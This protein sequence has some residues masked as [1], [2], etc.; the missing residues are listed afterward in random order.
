ME[1]KKEQKDAIQILHKRYITDEK[2]KASLEKERVNAEVA[3]MIHE[4]RVDAELSQ[5]ELADLI[6]TT[7]SVISRLEDD[8]Y[9]GHS[10]SMLNKISKALNKRLTIVMKTNDPEAGTLRYA[11]QVTL[12]NLRR[13]KGLT[14]EQLA[15]KTGISHDEVLAME[16]NDGYRPQPYTLHILSKFYGIP[17]ERLAALAGAFRE[18]PEDIKES[19]TRYAAQSESFAKLTKQE[20]RALDD[21]VKA[22]KK[23]K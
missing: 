23:D 3:R 4:L 11:F 2:R 7:Q 12:E 15:K 14:V 6:D 1:Q 22:L 16:R 9:E 21:F 18:I 10:L 17:D 19:A 5:Q 13:A 8:D 20:R